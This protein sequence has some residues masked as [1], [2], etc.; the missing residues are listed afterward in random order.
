MWEFFQSRNL[1]AFSVKG[2]T[3]NILYI[4]VQKI[5]VS[6][7]QLSAVA[8]QMIYGQYVA[9]FQL[10]CVT[11]DTTTVGGCMWPLGCILPTPILE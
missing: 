5:S 3:V 10:N 1:Q 8:A 2:P 9:E 7:I 6:T 11:L 4:V